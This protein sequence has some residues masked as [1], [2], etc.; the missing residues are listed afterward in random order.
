MLEEFK[1]KEIERWNTLMTSYAEDVLALQKQ[2]DEVE[3]KYRK[4]AEEETKNLTEAVE[5]YKSMEEDC[6]AKIAVLEGKTEEEKPKR[7]PR[8]PKVDSKPTP[9]PE[10]EKVIDTLFPENNEPEEEEKKEEPV[11]EE[12]VEDIPIEEVVE[13]TPEK[14]E[15]AE[16]W[17]EE[18]DKDTEESGEINAEEW[19]DQ[20]TEW[21]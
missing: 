10:P 20:P 8:K 14:G 4:L 19:P 21:I 18:D 7:Q 12:V 11:S 5:Y 15:L 6:K 13:E 2:I 17:P 1:T 3:E 9:E 16:L